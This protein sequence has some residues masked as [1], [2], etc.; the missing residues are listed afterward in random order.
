MQCLCDDYLAANEVGLAPGTTCTGTELVLFEVDHGTCLDCA[1]NTKP[2]IDTPSASNLDCEDPYTGA[3]A[4][5]TAAEC[6]AVLACDL[7]VNP[8]KTVPPITSTATTTPVIGYCGETA[9]PACQQ[10]SSAPTGGCISQISAAFP[11]GFSAA[12]INGNIASGPYAASRAGKI[13]T[14]AINNCSTCVSG[15]Q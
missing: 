9:I 2:C 8:R 11:A 13:I 4:G 14:C 7:G 5:E 12:Q 3:G 1:L 15:P 6:V 10:G